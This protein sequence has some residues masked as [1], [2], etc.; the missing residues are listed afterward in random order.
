MARRRLEDERFAYFAEAS[1]VF[2]DLPDAVF[3]GY[4]GDDELLGMPRADDDAPFDAAP[5]RDRPARAA[6]GLLPARRRRPRRPPALPRGRHPPA[7]G[8]PALGDARARLRRASS[9]FYEDFPYAWWNDFKGLED[10]GAGPARRPCRPTSRI[11]PELRRHHRPD[12]A[13]DHGHRPVREPARAAV[14]RHA[15]DGRLRSARTAGRSPS[16]ATSTGRPSGTGRPAASE[17]LS[18]GAAAERWSGRYV[19]ALV[20]VFL[21][22]IAHPRRALARPRA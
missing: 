5:P 6:E 4:E 14:R 17:P 18:Q 16:S 2:L 13:Q 20:A 21:A 7:P 19:A 10:L 15:R 22:G 8:G 11:V 1:I 12:R 9:T 3:R